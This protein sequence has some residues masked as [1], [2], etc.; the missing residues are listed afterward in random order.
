[1]KMIINIQII[2]GV[3]MKLLDLWKSKKVTAE[4]AP[5]KTIWD[6]AFPITPKPDKSS[7]STELSTGLTITFSGLM[8]LMPNP[9]PVL[10]KMGWNK[11]IDAYN[12]ILSDPQLYGAIENNRKPGVTSLQMYI[13][14]PDGD[15]NETEFIEQFVNGLKYRGIYDDLLNQALDTPQFGRMVFG[16]VWDVVNGKWLPV[17]IS[18]MPHAICKFDYDGRLKV[19]ED[20][21]NFEEP[22]HPARYIVLRHKASLVNPYG[23]ALLSRCYWNI[24]FKKDGLKLWAVFMERYGMP[25]VQASYNPAAIAKS[26]STD[27][28]T[29]A[30]TL[31]NKLST[32]AR[33]GIIVFPDGTK[34]DVTKTGDVSSVEI[35][36]KMI[37]ICDEQNTKLQLGHSGATESTSGDKLSNDTTATDV[38]QHVIDSDKKFPISLMNQLIYWIHQFNFNN[39]HIPTFN[40]YKEEDVDMLLAER[41]AALVPVMQLSNM[42]FSKDYFI[43]NYGFDIDDIMESPDAIADSKNIK[44]DAHAKSHIMDMFNSFY[45]KADD[46]SEYPEQVLIDEIV[47]EIV[48]D[49]NSFEPMLKLIKGYINK[50][51]DYESALD[52]LHKMY[53]KLN[54]KELQT[55][56]ER[57]LFV[58]DMIGRFSVQDEI[59]EK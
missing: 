27:M 45:A 22:K 8:N 3:K 54:T 32:M 5:E 38:R 10:K 20:G 26:F 41:D 21:I 12:E 11:D 6:A 35:F 49:D 23:E 28:T 25:W 48:E 33:N 52:N 4:V 53:P 16:V 24:R 50:Q 39:Q 17:Q 15:K 58:C 46:E 19:A 7:L 37:R 47:S 57:I 13:D 44:N 34:V 29:A 40:L 14:N 30:T 9:D 56:M 1:M 18:A 59:G 51:D 31:L 42:K 2:K 55:K 43:R 36:E